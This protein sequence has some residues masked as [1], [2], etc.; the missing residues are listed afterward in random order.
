MTT[1]AAGCTWH[2]DDEDKAEVPLQWKLAATELANQFYRVV[3]D[4]WADNRLHVVVYR[5]KDTLNPSFYYIVKKNNTM[6]RRE[7]RIGG[8]L[9]PVYKEKDRQVG[10][11]VTPVRRPKRTIH[12]AAEV[13]DT[14]RTFD[15]H[16]LCVQRAE[17]TD[18]LRAVEL[19]FLREPHPDHVAR[20]KLIRESM[21]NIEMRIVLAAS[22]KALPV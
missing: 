11:K 2:M 8:T 19:Q 12:R 22:Q 14:E 5:D 4:D 21:T 10:P 1:R 6:Y 15:F 3:C 18:D 17:L 16:S 7:T 20:M 9:W 13:H